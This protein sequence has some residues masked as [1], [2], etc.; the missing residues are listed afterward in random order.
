MQ[1][2]EAPEVGSAT[3]GAPLDSRASFAISHQPPP[4][5][6]FCRLVTYLSNSVVRTLIIWALV[7]YTSAPIT[8]PRNQRGVQL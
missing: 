7:V 6:I 2:Q 8:V 3:S 4:P 5:I 1:T